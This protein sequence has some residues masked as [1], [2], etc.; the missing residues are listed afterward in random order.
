VISLLAGAVVCLMHAAWACDTGT[1]RDAVARAKRDVHRLCVIAHEGDASADATF[2]GLESWL[3]DDAHALNVA[4]ERVNADDSG[5]QWRE[6][7]I[8]SVPPQLPVVVLAGEFASPHRVF[9]INHW[10]PG[11]TDSELAELLTSPAREAI[12]Q[13]LTER[14]AVILYAPATEQAN[15]AIEAAFAAVDAKWAADQSPGVSI[16]RMDR[17]NPRDQ[18]LRAFAGIEPSGPDW[19]G[20]VFGRGKL[21]APPLQ[22]DDITEANINGLL[23]RLAI[24]CTCLQQSMTFG[25]DIPMTWEAALDDKIPFGNAAPQGYV[26]MTLDTPAAAPGA[27]A[28]GVAALVDEIPQKEHWVLATALIPLAGAG[29]VALV[30]VVLV[31]QRSRRRNRLETRGGNPLS[32]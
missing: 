30:A 27:T 3:R 26:E 31:I 9:V 18:L 7:G 24:P 19:L 21:M 14:W 10:Q 13:A 2:T 29:V 8:P 16:V 20:I 1:V 4:L 23:Q 6:Y 12:K 28:P 32:S 25:L 11:P 17:S 15:P 5:L 22:G